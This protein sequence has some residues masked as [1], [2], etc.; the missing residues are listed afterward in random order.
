[1]TP[2]IVNIVLWM[3]WLRTLLQ[4][5]DLAAGGNARG[6]LDVIWIGAVS[7]AFGILIAVYVIDVKWM[8][9]I[10]AFIMATIVKAVFFDGFISS[11]PGVV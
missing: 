9:G 8:S 7:P 3:L 6:V 1:M 5:F 4:A 11:F 2:H 10:L